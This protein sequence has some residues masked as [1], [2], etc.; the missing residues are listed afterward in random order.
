[1]C[2]IYCHA[3]SLATR[4]NCSWPELYIPSNTEGEISDFD[5]FIQR[6]LSSDSKPEFLVNKPPCNT[7]AH[8][9]NKDRQ[10]YDKTMPLFDS[11]TKY[12]QLCISLINETLMR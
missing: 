11:H 3:E 12:K 5:L 9:S 6:L 7:S 8:F 2:Q 4:C 10:C 1:M